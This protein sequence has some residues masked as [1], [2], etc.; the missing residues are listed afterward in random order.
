[1]DEDHEVWLGCCRGHRRSLAEVRAA[2]AYG[3]DE[4]RSNKELVVWWRRLAWE[5]RCLKPL[6]IGLPELKPDAPAAVHQARGGFALLVGLRRVDYRAEPVP[7]SVR[8]SAAWCHLSKSAAHD[9]IRELR[10]L[11]VIRVV[12]GHGSLPLYEPGKGEISSSPDRV[13]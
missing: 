7:F 2:V 3:V 13:R 1:V 12:A 4:R 6:K 11:D 5:L 9:A 8:F 10:K